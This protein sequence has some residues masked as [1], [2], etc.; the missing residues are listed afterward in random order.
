MTTETDECRKALTNKLDEN[1][2]AIAMSFISDA[3]I[4][5][6]QLSDKMKCD[7]IGLS[8]AAIKCY[9]SATEPKASRADLL[10]GIERGD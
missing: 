6:P 1:A 2:Y 9:A 3:I 5:A 8:D 10:D 4:K 7:I